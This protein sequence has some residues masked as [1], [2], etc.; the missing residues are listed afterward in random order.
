MILVFIIV[1][2]LIQFV[3]H[4]VNHKYNSIIPDFIIVLIVLSFH[5]IFFPRLFVPE[6]ESDEINCGLPMFAVTFIFWIF[7]TIGS[8]VSYIIW[9]RFFLSLNQKNEN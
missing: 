3:G 5:Y 9:K 2:A 4:Y 6:L 8:I 1:V 7:G